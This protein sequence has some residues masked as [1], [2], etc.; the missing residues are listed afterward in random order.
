MAIFEKRDGGKWRA[1]V[2]RKGHPE[3]SQTFTKKSIAQSW[4][5]N[6]EL[7]IRRGEVVDL[8]AQR[9]TFSEIA[10]RYREEVTPRKRTARAEGYRITRLI[11]VFGAYS[12]A[13]I[14]PLDIAKFRDERVKD[15]MSGQTVIHDLNALSAIFEHARKEWGIWLSENP[16]RAVSK[17]TKA[18]GRSRRV[19]ALELDLLRRAADASPAHG[20]RS[21]LDLAIETACRLGELISLEWARVDL[22]RCT[23]HLVETKNGESRTV[24]LSAAAVATLAAMTRHSSGQVFW[25]WSG[26]DAFQPTWRKCVRRA[27][28]MY[29][30]EMAENGSKP[31]PEFL[32]DFRFHD[33][34]HEATSRLFERG[35]NTF[36]VASMTGHKSMQML[37]RYTHV[38]AEK[39][40][41]K[42]R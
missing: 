13:A 20:L 17:P 15:G 18:R 10:Q 37:S 26:S 11:N 35:I 27:R 25:N 32:A 22:S 16:A 34:R 9:V 42:L 41:L 19:S 29:E 24:A 33:L 14:R 39:L 5:Q 1:R 12:L 4:A 2:R 40:A 8:Q 31:A 7:K 28:A 30:V 23:L 6:I 36:E 3:V 21:I 38:D